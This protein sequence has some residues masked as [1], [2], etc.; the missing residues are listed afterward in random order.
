MTWPGTVPYVTKPRDQF[1][2]LTRYV[3]IRSLSYSFLHYN[4][5][6][7]QTYGD[8]NPYI[9]AGQL[10]H[11]TSRIVKRL[12]NL[13]LPVANTAA[14]NPLTDRIALDMVVNSV[15]FPLGRYMFT[16]NLQQ[17]STGG[18]E[19]EVQ[20]VDE[21]F[22]V[23]QQ[24]DTSFSV[25]GD[26]VTN[27]IA[28]LLSGFDLL[29]EVETSPYGA[30]LSA[31]IG[32]QR[33]QILETLS[34][35]GDYQTPWMD[36]T[37]LFRMVRTIDPA[38][39][40]A[41]I[42]F[43]TDKRIAIDTITRTTDILNAPNRYVVVSNSG[44]TETSDQPVVGVYDVPPSAPHSIQSR[45]FVIPAVIDVQL[46]DSSQALAVA[47]NIG[48]RST[49]VERVTFQSAP[50]PRHDS[51]DVCIFDEDQWLETSWTLDLQP[52]GLMT[53]TIVRAYA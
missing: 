4:G 44:S 18:N 25:S 40:E 47:R 33:G 22:I 43:D 51:Y 37:G 2:D 10:N 12:L 50:D 28:R 11:D 7:G 49:V 34:T 5:V 13:S 29:A 1:L 19:A 52:T 9:S 38:A 42:D 6:T 35:Q 24:I 32:T 46:Q 8:L 15:P 27:A 53:N 45:G 21:M 39:A 26:N 17:V 41:S 36:H 20:L 23:D 30:N 3:G 31:P 14:I 16:D 48:L